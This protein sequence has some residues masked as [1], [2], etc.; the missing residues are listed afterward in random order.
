MPL[1]PLLIFIVVGVNVYIMLS[2][3]AMTWIRFIV[4]LVVGKTVN[5]IL[6]K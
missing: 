1:L 2:L 6:I 3:S 5:L 4:W